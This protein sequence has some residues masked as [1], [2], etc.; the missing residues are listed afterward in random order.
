MDG[1]CFILHGADLR[2]DVVDSG[3]LILVGGE[4]CPVLRVQNVVHFRALGRCA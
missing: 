2:Y 3:Q 1:H 4:R